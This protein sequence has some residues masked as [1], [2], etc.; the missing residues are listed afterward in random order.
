MSAAYWSYTGQNLVAS[1]SVS[2][3]FAARIFFFSARRL[4]RTSARSFSTS[5]PVAVSCWAT[6]LLLGAARATTMVR[7]VSIFVFKRSPLNVHQRIAIGGE[8]PLS[9]F[10]P[11]RVRTAT[12]G[13]RRAAGA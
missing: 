2:G 10:R 8:N 4:R 1:V 11:S 9:Y 12:G 6:L 13:G 3:T 5:I 7:H